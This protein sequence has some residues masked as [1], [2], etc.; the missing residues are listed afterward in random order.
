MVIGM[1]EELNLI[2]KGC[3]EGDPIS[4]YFFILAAEIL[5]I[6]VDMNPNI[7]GIDIGT[8]NFR[9]TQFAD[10]TTLVLDG[11]RCSLQAAS[12]VLEIFGSYSGLRM[13]TEKKPK[14]FGLGQGNTRKNK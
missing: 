13:N 4:S 8:Q 9:I 1:L 5:R 6:L 12:N 3:R 14:L 10:D 2:D 7:K 11:S